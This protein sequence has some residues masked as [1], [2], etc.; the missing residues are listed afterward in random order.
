MKKILLA[1]LACG[2]ILAGSVGVADATLITG[3]LWTPADASAAD[4]GIVPIGAPTATFTV[5]Q[6]YFDS[7]LPNFTGTYDNFLKGINNQL[8][9]TNLDADGDTF[10]LDINSFYTSSGK[11]TF[12]QFTGYAYFDANTVVTH[13]DGFYLTLGNNVYDYSDPVSPTATSLGNA[14][15]YYNFTMN[16]GA[17]NGFPEVLICDT[18]APVP[19]PATMLLMGTGLA[20]LVA[21]NRRRKAKKAE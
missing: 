14:A 7:R 21:A 1:G 10:D 3:S 17:W 18:T 9:W 8:V 19:E 13:D 12:F 5:D 20:G 11:G 2:M 15:G 16:Y 6:L 4:P